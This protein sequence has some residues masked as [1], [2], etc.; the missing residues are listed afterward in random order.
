[1]H[2]TGGSTTNP[3][4]VF[5]CESFDAWNDQAAF[6]GVIGHVGADQTASACQF[7]G[8]FKREP[9]L[10]HQHLHAAVLPQAKEHPDAG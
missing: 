9:V 7:T 2:K 8:L 4:G 10:A 5:F 1:M 6:R 3:V